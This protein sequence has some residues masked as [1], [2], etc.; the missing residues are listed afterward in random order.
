MSRPTAYGLAAHGGMVSNRTRMTAYAEALRRRVRPGMTV[1]DLGA[2][3]G[4]FSLL[5]C[6]CGA[7]RVHAVDPDG[8][9]ALLAELAAANGCADRIE[10]HQTLST[11]LELASPADL[12]VSD[13]RGVLPLFERHI[14]AIIDARRRLLIPG[15]TLIPRADSLWAAP[16][17]AAPELLRRLREPWLVNEL[18]L[19]LGAGHRFVVNSW[20]RVELGAE[21]LLAEPRLWARLDYPSLVGPDLAGRLDWRLERAGEAHGLA[22]WFDAELAEGVGFSNAPGAKETIYG[23]AFFPWPE[24]VELHPGDRVAVELRAVLTGDDYTWRWRSTVS[25]AGGRTTAAFDQSTF[26]AAPLASG[27]LRRREAGFVPE[28]GPE[29][30]VDAFLLAQMDGRTDLEEIA[31]RAAARFPER[32]PEWR[33][34]LGRAGE[35]SEKFS[36]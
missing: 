18:G 19:A 26:F 21:S 8:S 35:L 14:P 9:T 5:A 6:R 11:G 24:P 25:G 23:Q 27:K 28:L 31:R 3:P 16:V 12:I 10:I 13:L 20:R 34:A 7:A 29:G 30:E 15:G 1:L 4:V 33:D 17:T 32:F 36:R 22:V 2:G